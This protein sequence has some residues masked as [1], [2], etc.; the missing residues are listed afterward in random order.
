MMAHEIYLNLLMSKHDRKGKPTAMTEIMQKQ[1]L[2]IQ[3]PFM[4]I[5]EG[6]DS[7]HFFEYH[8]EGII[9]PLSFKNILEYTGDR[10]NSFE[11][12]Q[13]EY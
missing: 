13:R 2:L 3:Q 9:I 8:P 12:L 1:P 10:M 5:G 6:D 11:V 7:F 4:P